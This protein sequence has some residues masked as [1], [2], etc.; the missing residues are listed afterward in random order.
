M[1]APTPAD[2][3]L[4]AAAREMIAV[5]QQGQSVI[6]V[7]K[8]RCPHIYRQI[9][10]DRRYP[11]LLALWG[12]CVDVD[13]NVGQ[14]IVHPAILTAIGALGGVPMRGR[15]VHAGLQHTYGYLFS[16]IETPYGR[17]RTRWVTPDLE[18]SFGLD[19]SLLGERPR[20]GS[21]LANVTWFLGNI[22]Y[23]DLPRDL[24]R[25]RRKQRAAA[26]ELVGYDYAG[27]DVWRLE[28]RAAVTVGGMERRIL[29][30]TDVVRYP[31]SIADKGEV[32][33]LIYSVQ[34]GERATLKLITAFPIGAEALAQL[35][36]S[37]RRKIRPRA[38]YNAY[39]PEL[40]R[41]RNPVS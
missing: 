15:I 16:L 24:R 2:R 31:R 28:E 3:R 12:R 34:R 23:R 11:E 37:A 22:V 19:L 6:A 20:A 21:L 33:L 36:A 32:A 26:P 38:R 7:L 1:P 35:Q 17:K 27:L 10:H 18:R 39:V 25:L 41:P 40:A 4:D 5:A 9:V 14:V 29:L 13:E 8:A 30:Q